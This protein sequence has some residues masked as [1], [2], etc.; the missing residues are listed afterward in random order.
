MGLGLLGHCKCGY[1]KDVYI[2]SGFAQHGKSFEYPHYCESCNSLTSVDVLKKNPKCAECGSEDIKSY[3][4]IT[5]ELPD[6]VS[7]LPYFM[8]KDYHKPEDVQEEDFC[9]PL[10]KTFVLLKGNH[11]CPR[12]KENSLIFKT[13]VYCD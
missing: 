12:C 3:E 6:D 5:K 2:G 1:E 9:Y 13:T 11:Y 8:M 4:A 7:G 10:D